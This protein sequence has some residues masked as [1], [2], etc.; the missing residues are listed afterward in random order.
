MGMQV[1]KKD[2]AGKIIEAEIKKIDGSQN[3]W[4]GDTQ[5]SVYSSY[6]KVSNKFPSII[7]QLNNY[8]AFLKQTVSNYKLGDQS[9]DTDISDNEESLKV[10]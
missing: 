8:S 5:K 4:K 2:L 3:T 6:L 7:E 9:I 10:N 1:D